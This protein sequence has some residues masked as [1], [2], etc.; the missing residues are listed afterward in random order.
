MDLQA[1]KQIIRIAYYMACIHCVHALGIH[2]ESVKCM[3]SVYE[4]S[5][6]KHKHE[7]ISTLAIGTV[8][9]K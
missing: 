8:A 9:D 5:K 2:I 1:C 7:Y 6:N 4:H 3:H